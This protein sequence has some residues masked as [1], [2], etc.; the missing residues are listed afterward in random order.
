MS[1]VFISY[2]H[3]ERKK[4]E[5]LASTLQS[6]G[7]TPWL[8]QKHISTPMVLRDEILSKLDTCRAFVFLVEPFK[9]PSDS[10]QFEYM[11]ALESVW[12]HH[13]KLL[14]PVLTGEGEAPPFL[15]PFHV[16]RIPDRRKDWDVFLGR[17]ADT[18]KESH[19]PDSQANRS[20]QVRKQWKR[21]L[22]EVETSA[23][24]IQG[25]E[26]IEGATHYLIKRDPSDQDPSDRDAIGLLK[27]QYKRLTHGAKKTK[28]KR[29][30]SSKKQIAG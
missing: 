2:S 29:R 12:K 4:A 13:D 27:T 5:L 15:R 6:R 25:E 10:L 20:G 3:K 22:N 8:A 14:I 18:I 1:E 11:A 7:L 30:A 17:L 26:I 9:K 19:K 16:W 21:I 28:R 23:R 24:R